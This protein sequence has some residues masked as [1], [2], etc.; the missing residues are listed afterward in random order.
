MNRVGVLIAAIA[1]LVLSV[2]LYILGQRLILPL[3]VAAERGAG[4]PW[5]VTW[6]MVWITVGC[7]LTLGAFLLASLRNPTRR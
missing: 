1:C 3:S 6:A 4:V 2:A 7:A 5:Y